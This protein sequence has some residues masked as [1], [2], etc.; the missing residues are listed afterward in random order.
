MTVTFSERVRSQL[1]DEVLDAAS[2]AVFAGGWG[3]LRMQ[4]VADQVGISRRTLYYEFG[5]KTGLA[6]ALILRITARF[7]DG[8]EAA[9]TS[10]D[11]LSRGW[12]AAVLSALRAAEVDPVLSTVLTGNA[13]EDFLPLLTSEGTQVID[14]ATTR[15]TDAALTRWPELP[16]RETTLAAEA[17]V[18]LALSH[19]VRPGGDTGQAAHDIAELATGYLGGID[20]TTRQPTA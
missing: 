19:I 12:E 14:H 15:M 6:E 16:S 13:R 2:T 8:V 4:A 3:A 1:R 10:A 17:T 7:L 9:F 18:R 20:R 5:N 11:D